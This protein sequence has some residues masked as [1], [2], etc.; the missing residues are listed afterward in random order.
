MHV[1]INYLQRPISPT[2]QAAT[3]TV[4][5]QDFFYRAVHCNMGQI[6]FMS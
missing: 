2:A 3:P 6:A 1:D 5:Q 4:V